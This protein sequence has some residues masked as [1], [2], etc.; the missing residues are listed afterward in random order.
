MLSGPTVRRQL[1]RVAERV[2]TAEVATHQTW[3][4]TGRV[5][6]PAGERVVAP[7]YV[8]ADGVWVKT[9]REPAH[10]TGYEIKCASAYEG[11]ERVGEPTPGHPRPHFGLVAKQVYCHLHA[12]ET[13]PFWEGASLALHCTYDLSAFR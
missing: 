5:P 13:L 3:T 12:R 11:W 2:R 6:A 4:Q 7:L 10:R 1:R 8:E 9:Q